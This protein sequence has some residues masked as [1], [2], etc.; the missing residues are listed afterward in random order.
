MGREHHPEGRDHRVEG[1]V[2]E[3]QRF[4]VGFLERDRKPVG[5]GTGA[6]ALEQCRYVIGRHDIAPA[7]RRGEA[8]IAVAGG[9]VEYFLTGAKIKRLAQ[10]FAD[11]LQGRADDGVV[12]GRPGRLLPGLEVG[13]IGRRRCRLVG[14]LKLGLCWRHCCLP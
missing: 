8:H 1:A 3:R 11:D 5:G 4:G 13:E 6:A 2:G 7:S 10:F 14:W 9:D 12:A